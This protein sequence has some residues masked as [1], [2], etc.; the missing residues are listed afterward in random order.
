[1]VEVGAMSHARL[2]GRQQMLAEILRLLPELSLQTTMKIQFSP[3][4]L[5]TEVCCVEDCLQQLNTM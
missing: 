3:A 5:K 2:P 4:F 1:M